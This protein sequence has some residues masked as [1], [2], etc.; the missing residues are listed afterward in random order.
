MQTLIKMF[1]AL[2]IRIVGQSQNKSRLRQ[3]PELID[4]I[5]KMYGSSGF[6]CAC[7]SGILKSVTRLKTELESRSVNLTSLK[8]ALTGV[9]A[10]K[11]ILTLH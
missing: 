1:A 2:R 11:R 4:G 7:Q 6:V 3:S 5:C 8:S 9:I 10:G